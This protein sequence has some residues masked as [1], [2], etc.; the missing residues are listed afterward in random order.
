[1]LS[2]DLTKLQLHEEKAWADVRESPG[3]GVTRHRQP[4]IVKEALH[5]ALL[6]LGHGFKSSQAS[7]DR[8]SLPTLCQ[9]A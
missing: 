9:A 3:L 4:V 8:K 7:P 2:Q 5:Q 1:M 6:P